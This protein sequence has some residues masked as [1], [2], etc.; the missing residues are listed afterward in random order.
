MQLFMT[1]K[2][3]LF[4]FLCFAYFTAIADQRIDSFD[5]Q[6][7]H[8]N[9]S[10]RQLS[11]RQISGFTDLKIK[12]NL[13]G[14]S[15]VRLNLLG[16]NVT[17]ITQ[18]D[19]QL[20][21]VRLDDHLFIEL[22]Q[23]VSKNDS[24]T[25]RVYYHGQP[26]ADPRWG[27]F[28]FS[29]NYAYN[30]GVGMGSIPHTFGRCWYP[31]VDNFTDRATYEFT[32]TTDSG[33]T[34]VCGG[35]L[36]NQTHAGDSSIWH[37]KLHQ[38]I[39][40][41]LSSVAVGKYVFV[42]NTYKGIPVWL[43]VQAND[44]NNLKASFAPLFDALDCF[45]SRF[46]PYL[47]DRVGFVGVPFNAG[48]ME[49]AANIAYPLYAINGTL[50]NE[51]L[52]AHELSHHW[53]GNLVTCSSS[54]DMW[55]NEGWASFCEAVY[56][57]CR[58]GKQAYDDNI[59]SKCT[60]VN[61]NA[62]R[63]DGG[64]LPVSGVGFTNTYGRHVYTKG[65][66]VAHNLRVTMGDSAFFAACRSY[67]NKYKFMDASSITLRNEFQP[68]APYPLQ[69]F[70]EAMVFDS[71][72]VSVA[73]E[74]LRETTNDLGEFSTYL[75]L[76]ETG[77]FKRNLNSV[78]SATL[79]VIYRDSIHHIHVP[80]SNGMSN[81]ILV[82]GSIF[83]NPVYG[84]AVNYT[85][86]TALAV[87]HE[88]RSIKT[89][90]TAVP[91]NNALFSCNVRTIERDS[92]VLLVS[93]HWTPPLDHTELYEQGIRINT[94]RYWVIENSGSNDVW[95]FFNYDG[96][97]S[98]FLDNQ[99]MNNLASEDSLVLLFRNRLSSAKRFRVVDC[100]HQPGASKTDKTG[101][102]W[103]D[104]LN[105]GEYAFGIRDYRVVGMAPARGHKKDF[106]WMIYPNPAKH[107]VILEFSQGISARLLIT[108]VLGKIHYNH[109]GEFGSSKKIDTQHLPSGVYW[110]SI[111][112]DG[113]RSAKLLK[114]E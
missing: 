10:I 90:G 58:Y 28:F 39:P 56:L 113:Q 68:F 95:G 72:Q 14:L 77:K 5:V 16:L 82:E 20:I 21:F 79:S 70:F 101:R 63:Q 25:L 11:S 102:F 45:E 74:L 47:F 94:D 66:L 78:R 80:L 30:M 46:G 71:G 87:N 65:A 22:N 83:Y 41:Y 8:I 60:D 50:A 23:S 100:T 38:T 44:T 108:D 75:K 76:K 37:W 15:R 51:T 13:N 35:L 32:I 34:A 43:A 92:T 85:Q 96:T 36:I 107:E 7:Y 69:S 91:M 26:Q 24:T 31:C 109:E 12:S 53:W 19:S 89:T 67:L 81:E 111:E 17:A 86:G 9:L 104:N 59:R 42:K 106:N 52:L 54:A 61:L 73:I 2:T 49:H 1:A 6:H 93:H 4:L 29:G 97:A 55:L 105:S 33:F 62:A 88:L 48:A 84:M 110:L 114:I 112:A 103:V 98:A 64:W 40:T 3:Q 57:E 18:N 27:G 99:F